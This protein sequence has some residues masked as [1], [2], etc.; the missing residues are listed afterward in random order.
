MR[1]ARAGEESLRRIQGAQ[2]AL[3]IFGMVWEALNGSRV[4]VNMGHCYSSLAKRTLE[5]L[6]YT[7]TTCIKSQEKRTYIPLRKRDGS[8]EKNYK[9][10]QQRNV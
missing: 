3:D 6:N 9:D 8:Q 7:S 2:E 4:C 1:G 5:I 10:S